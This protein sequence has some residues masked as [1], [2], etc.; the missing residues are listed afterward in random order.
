MIVMFDVQNCFETCTFERRFDAVSWRPSATR[1]E[2]LCAMS[3]DHDQR[4]ERN[5]SST[6]GVVTSFVQAKRLTLDAIQTDPLNA[7]RLPIPDNAPSDVLVAA[8]TAV[9]TIR[10]ESL[11]ASQ[12]NLADKATERLRD[13]A[14]RLLTRSRE[15]HQ[16]EPESTG[17]GTPANQNPRPRDSVAD[18][19]HIPTQNTQQSNAQAPRPGNARDFAVAAR[20]LTRTARNQGERAEASEPQPDMHQAR[21]NAQH[22]M[23]IRPAI[24]ADLGRQ[25]VTTVATAAPARRDGGLPKDAEARR[26]QQQG[27]KS[28]NEQ[29]TAQ[30]VTHGMDSSG[31][32][33]VSFKWAAAL[34]VLKERKAQ[35]SPSRDAQQERGVERS[36]GRGGWHMA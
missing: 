34:A 31:S 12:D 25:T 3:G 27:D 16:G 19:G 6:R 35:A 13:L 8:L 36:P 18:L 7:I 22:R 2:G 24:V 1:T 26:I 5:A 11:T 15:G 29:R 32:S 17:V 10:D 23:H 14:E 4:T 9:V 33:D 30:N 21:A 20:T 28:A